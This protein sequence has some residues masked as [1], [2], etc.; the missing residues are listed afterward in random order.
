MQFNTENGSIDFECRQVVVAGW[1][2]RDTHAVQHH[3]EELAAIGVAP[4]SKVP[5]FYR[6]S[7]SLLTA[8]RNIEVLGTASSGEAEPLVIRHDGKLWLGLASDHTDRQLET[9]SVAASK[10]ICG[11]P[12]ATSLWE[13]A[14]LEGRL[15]AIIIKSWIRENG[16]WVLYQDGTIGQIKPLR[17]LI[18]AADLQNGSAMLCG[19]FAAL[20]GVRA[21]EDFRA[22]MTDPETGAEIT[23]EYTARALP[24]VS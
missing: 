17:D 18:A 22:T 12:C 8:E 15:D 14:S 3:I 4:P 13:F 21:A 1:T 2:G 7:N 24:E 5:L 16:D 9:I 10:Q 20:G 11:K 19:T 23:L 6:V